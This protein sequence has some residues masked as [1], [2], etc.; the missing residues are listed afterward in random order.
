MIGLKKKQQSRCS[1]KAGE[2][3]VVV[4][5]VRDL[6]VLYYVLFLKCFKVRIDELNL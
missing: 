5:V 1:L 6:S 3:A 2:T 4:G